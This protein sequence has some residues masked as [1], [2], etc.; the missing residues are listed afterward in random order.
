MSTDAG[1]GGVSE[2]SKAAVHDALFGS[3]K[4]EDK[5]SQGGSSSKDK[6]EDDDLLEDEDLDDGDSDDNEDDGDDDKQDVSKLPQW[7]QDKLKKI[8]ADNFK[9]RDAARKARTSTGAKPDATKGGSDKDDKGDGDVDKRIEDAKT[10]ARLDAKAE[11]SEDLVATRLEAA[12]EALN[13]P[14]ASDIVSDLNLGKYV[15]D[16]GEIDKAKLTAKIEQFKTTYGRRRRSSGHGNSGGDKGSGAT[17]AD[18]F[19]EAIGL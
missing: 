10:Q 13:V 17:N 2:E 8:E 7:A 18:R 14:G 3:D 12:L 19:A 16:E 9:Y 1:K 6:S 5:G 4:D 15:T 11:Y